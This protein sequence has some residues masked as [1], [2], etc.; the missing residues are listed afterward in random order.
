M[1][2]TQCTNVNGQRKMPLTVLVILCFFVDPVRLSAGGLPSSDKHYR[3]N[4][5]NDS[6]GYNGYY[7]N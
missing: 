1:I 7:D 3:R 4:C 2:S 5:R 6:N